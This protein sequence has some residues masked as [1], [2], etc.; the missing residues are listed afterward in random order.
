MT[1]TVDR[2]QLAA[3]GMLRQRFGNVQVLAV[4]DQPATQAGGP[5]GG[6]RNASATRSFLKEIRPRAAPRRLQWPSPACF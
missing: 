2:E 3:L 6:R 1:P 5:G 4:I